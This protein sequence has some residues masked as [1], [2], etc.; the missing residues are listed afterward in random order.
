[1]C[2]RVLFNHTHTNTH[3]LS[4]SLSLSLSKGNSTFTHVLYICH[5]DVLVGLSDMSVRLAQTADIENLGYLINSFD[6]E[7]SLTNHIAELTKNQ[8]GMSVLSDKVKD[9]D[10]VAFVILVENKIVGFSIMNKTWTSAEDIEILKGQFQLEDYIPFGQYK[11]IQQGTLTHYAINPK[12]NRCT[13][14]ALKECMRLYK[15]TLL[16]YRQYNKDVINECIL[17]EMTTVRSRRLSQMT[18][19]NESNSKA[20]INPFSLYFLSYRLLS[21]PKIFKN[22]RIVVVG[23]SDTG[24]ASLETLVFTPYMRFPHLTLVSPDGF[25]EAN[26][27]HSKS[28]LPLSCDGFP[29]G[30]SRDIAFKSNVRIVKARMVDIDRE[31]QCIILSDESY[32]AYDILVITTGLQDGTINKIQEENDSLSIPSGVLSLSGNNISKY[33]EKELSKGSSV[34]KHVVLYGSDISIFSAVHAL[35]SRG[36]HGEAITLVYPRYNTLT[37]L[38][39]SMCI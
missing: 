6:N 27:D 20:N 10:E 38:Y 18:I 31:G 21:E 39:V 5:R 1:M 22:D 7:T 30:G 35:I 13:R 4:L 28:F 37:I 32:L 36:V 14:F 16:Y 33:I 8:E 34:S 3:T 26:N 12:F 17:N 2:V 29:A 9:I 11:A 23:A 15:R 24:I 19:N 25:R